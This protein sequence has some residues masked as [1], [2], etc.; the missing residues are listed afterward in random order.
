MFQVF[1]FLNF[2]LINE[3]DLRAKFCSHSFAD[4]PVILLNSS[5]LLT[6]FRP[7]ILIAFGSM[8]G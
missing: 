3:I 4:L 5:Q 2:A 8:K 6:D 7:G 1:E